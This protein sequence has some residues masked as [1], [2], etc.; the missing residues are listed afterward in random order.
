MVPSNFFIAVFLIVPAAVQ[1]PVIYTSQ[2][3]N[4]FF[5][6]AAVNKNTDLSD[7]KKSILLLPALLLLLAAAAQTKPAYVL[8]NAKGKKVSYGKMIKAL[9]QQQVVLIGEFHNNAISHWMELEIT[10][11]CK[12]QVPLVLGAE[13]FEQ[14]NRES[15]LQRGSTVLPA[16]G[17]TTPPIMPRW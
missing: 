8:Y 15:F 11:D 1:Q 17:R 6:A 3:K 14:D 16:C 7:M 13:M 9:A 4:P 5:Y 10:K 12:Q 2:L